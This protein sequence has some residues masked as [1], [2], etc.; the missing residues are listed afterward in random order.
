MKKV[1][2]FLALFFIGINV[3]SGQQKSSTYLWDEFKDGILIFKDN[4]RQEGYVN[5]HYGLNKLVFLTDK[6]STD[7]YVLSK[8]MGLAAVSSG[9][10]MFYFDDNDYVWEIIHQ[11]PVIKLTHRG[12]YSDTGISTGYG[13]STSTM[14]TQVTSLNSGGSMHSLIADNRY[15]I[16]GVEKLFRIIKDDKERQF[17]NFKQLANAYPKQY[18]KTIEEYA[19][20]NNLSIKNIEDVLAVVEFAESLE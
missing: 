4:S 20:D 15:K 6:N 14:G 12:K 8:D 9:T 18:R 11:S 1:F 2:M 7:G 3:V 5:Y 13:N 16:T 19:K 10:T 17:A